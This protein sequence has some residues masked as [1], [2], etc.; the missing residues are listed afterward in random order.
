MSCGSMQPHQKEFRVTR[1]CAVRASVGTVF[2]PGS[3]SSS[4]TQ[5]NHRLIEWIRVL[6]QQT[7]AAYGARKMWQLLTREGLVCGRPRVVRLRL[8]AGTMAL[9][10]R[11]LFMTGRGAG[12]ESAP[13]LVGGGRGL[14][15]GVAA[16]TS[17]P[18]TGHHSTKVINTASGS[19]VPCL[20][21]AEWSL[22]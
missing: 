17:G 19:I 8:M 12:H 5:A 13:N 1:M 4:R 22:A 21:D 11:S 2:M 9:R 7:R 14:V 6:H 3:V 20:L 10:T 16:P 18:G 15:D